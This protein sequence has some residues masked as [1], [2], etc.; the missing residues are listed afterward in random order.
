MFLSSL[1]L[2]QKKCFLGLAKEILIADDGKI[3]QHEEAYLNGLCSEM[4]LSFNDE[5]QIEKSQLV[6]IFDETEVKR[7]VLLELVALGYSNGSYD[8]AQD[9]YTDDMANTLGIPMPDLREIEA[10]LKEYY[11]FQNKFIEFIEK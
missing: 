7:V 3:D 5:S 8:N 4:S 2:D 11:S 9:K 1:T 10:L 6:K